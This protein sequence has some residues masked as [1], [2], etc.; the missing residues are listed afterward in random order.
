[1]ASRKE[2]AM[3]LID[4]LFGMLDGLF[5]G[6]PITVSEV[7]DTQARLSTLGCILAR[8]GAEVA[9]MTDRLKSLEADNRELKL[10]VACLLEHLVSRRLAT[11][12]DLLHLAGQIDALDGKIDGAF[13]G[14]LDIGSG[15]TA[16]PPAPARSDLDELKRVVEQEQ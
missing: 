11:R 12:E 15:P 1:M 10:I 16:K 8:K 5:R 9:S 14:R 4:D 3:G 13:D 7:R 6:P 2:N